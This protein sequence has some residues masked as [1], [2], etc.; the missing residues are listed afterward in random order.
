MPR[1]VSNRSARRAVVE[2]TV[3]VPTQR[4][5]RST[6]SAVREP[7]VVVPK[8]AKSSASLKRTKPS[9]KPSASS[10]STASSKALKTA[11]LKTAG[12]GSKKQHADEVEEV[13]EAVA[14]VVEDERSLDEVKAQLAKLQAELER[15]NQ[16]G[17][18]EEELQR[19]VR[20]AQSRL[21]PVVAQTPVESRALSKRSRSE[22]SPA[23][24]LSP[25]GGVASSDPLGATQQSLLRA[26]KILGD[27]QTPQHRGRELCWPAGT[28]VGIPAFTT[29]LQDWIFYLH[30]SL[31]DG[32]AGGAQLYQMHTMVSPERQRYLREQGAVLVLADT[33]DLAQRYHDTIEQLLPLCLE[34]VSVSSS[35]TSALEET[36]PP[37]P[38][39]MSRTVWLGK[40]KQLVGRVHELTFFL[41]RTQN[42]E[43]VQLDPGL[44]QQQVSD[45]IHARVKKEHA[46]LYDQIPP[47]LKANKAD[48]RGFLLHV[49]QRVQSMAIEDEWAQQILGSQT[50]SGGTNLRLSREPSKHVQQQRG[51][52]TRPQ[53]SKC[54][55][56]GHQAAQCRAKERTPSGTKSVC[57]A[58]QQAG[59]K[60]SEC[61]TA[62]TKPGVKACFQ[63]GS[64]SHLRAD[65]PK[66]E[67]TKPKPKA[68]IAS[69]PKAVE[70]A[71]K[72]QRVGAVRA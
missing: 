30:T 35:I 62:K 6:R 59:H 65:C 33:E 9:A 58:C 68:E 25:S 47:E 16:R 19:E 52:S 57:Y 18:V 66:R 2:P 44:L 17:V 50:W 34:S 72:K 3:V 26:V 67:V 20:G 53:C 69:K 23:V 71:A 46:W 63:C 32:T 13:V 45:C 43:L 24:Q 51:G 54:A 40:V 12:G 28:G 36:F 14:R 22:G 15:L 21:T 55:K 49:A 38:V 5:K 64:E 37:K 39:H 48:W 1:S 60:A 42:G 10:K 27:M 8:R 7:E 31:Q 70:A 41:A 61:P 4:L 29:A 11:A 56:F